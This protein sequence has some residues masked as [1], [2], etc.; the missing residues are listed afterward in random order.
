[1]LV[2][3]EPSTNT[4]CTENNP[5]ENKRVHSRYEHLPDC[6]QKDDT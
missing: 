2:G 3:Q 4:V 1:M 6:C 5:A